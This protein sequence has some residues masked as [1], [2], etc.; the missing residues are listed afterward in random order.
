MKSGNVKS[1]EV[2]FLGES[3]N[4]DE[5]KTV[6]QICGWLNRKKRISA[7]VG[8]QQDFM[9]ICSM[10]SLDPNFVDFGVYGPEMLFRTTSAGTEHE[11]IYSKDPKLVSRYASVFREFWNSNNF[12]ETPDPKLGLPGN[13]ETSEVYRITLTEPVMIENKG[14]NDE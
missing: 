11:G 4:D 5:M 3:L 8:N 14:D 2:L 1:L 10:N 7:K 9:M 12:C 6:R 13:T